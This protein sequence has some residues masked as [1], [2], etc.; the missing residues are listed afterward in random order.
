M[1]DLVIKA[2]D[3]Y[4]GDLD[5]PDNTLYGVVKQVMALDRSAPDFEEQLKGKFKRFYHYEKLDMYLKFQSWLEHYGKDF[6]EKNILP[7]KVTTH[8]KWAKKSNKDIWTSG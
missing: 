5:A 8:K 4:A 6:I 1:A 7:D 2:E 3:V